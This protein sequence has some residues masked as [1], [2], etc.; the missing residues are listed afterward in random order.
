MELDLR[1]QRILR[2]IVID[3]VATA[4]PVGSHVLVERYS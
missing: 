4:E 3:Y 1:K 2:A